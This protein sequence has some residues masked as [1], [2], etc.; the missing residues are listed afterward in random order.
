MAGP[1]V[2]ARSRCWF[3]GVICIGAL[4]APA[5]EPPPVS[6]RT[7]IAPLL[8]RRCA[9][10]H[11]EENAK[12]RYRLDSFARL[13][14]PGETDLAPLV[15]GKPQE[16][17]LYLRLIEP[18]PHDRMPQKADP[19]PRAEIALIE[20][21]MLEGATY[22]GGAAERPL[23][24]LARESLL[25]AAPQHYPRPPAISALAF[26]PNGA[27]IAV[28]G[29]YEVTVWNLADGSLNRRIGGLPERITAL[30]WHPQRDLLAVAGGS[31][32]LWGAVALI[33]PT[34]GWEPRILCDLAD[35]ALSVAFNPEGTELAAGAADR[36]LR[37]FDATT[38][39]P[40]RIL[41]VHA[42]WVQSVAFDPQG[43][44]IV[45]ASRDRTAR[46]FNARNGDLEATYSGHEMPVLGAVFALD[47]DLVYSFGRG[48]SV[49]AW[50]PATGTKKGEA[51]TIEAEVQQL[52]VMPF[53]L[54]TAALDKQ[55]RVHQW[56]DRQQL[57]ALRGHGDWVQA[58]AISPEGDLVATGSA[59]GTVC[60]WNLACGTWTQRFVASP[61]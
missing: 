2:V 32:G 6:F 20:R 28:S 51:L 1:N 25:R 46:I 11:N 21:W 29:Y 61:R 53:G 17:E 12:G 34:R 9:T 16:S 40:G 13:A 4:V 27:Q 58:L 10:C 15:G 54:I 48:K 23:V 3:A 52:G 18:D 60:L 59:D 42:D 47:G 35:T 57:F 24:E 45:T 19:L 41:R 33:D 50:D 43:R 30:A 44:R 22:D 14:Q 55:V 56:G 38:G 26:S 31:P 36:T 7:E 8:H 5:E 39:K 37:F 49:H